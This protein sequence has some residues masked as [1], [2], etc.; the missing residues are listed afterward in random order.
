MKLSQKFRELC[1][2]AQLYFVIS[3][4]TIIIALAN[5]LK[6]AVV[7]IKCLFVIV[8]TFLL[9]FL[10]KKGYKNI[11]WFLV[12]LPY[13]IMMIICLTAFFKIKEGFE[14][15]IDKKMNS[16]ETKDDKKKDIIASGAAAETMKEAFGIPSS[17]NSNKNKR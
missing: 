11:S 10:C 1:T 12:L 5:G 3:V 6:L 8:W 14:I 15:E 13:I 4:I 9:N 17:Y 16:N 7:L 2:P